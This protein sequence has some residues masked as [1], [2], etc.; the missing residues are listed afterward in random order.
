MKCRIKIWSIKSKKVF[1]KVLFYDFILDLIFNMTT[2]IFLAYEEYLNS[3]TILTLKN[4]I[5]NILRKNSN[6][7]NDLWFRIKLK[8]G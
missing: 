8:L 7:K 1:L 3:G 2:S 4:Q 6:I 5:I